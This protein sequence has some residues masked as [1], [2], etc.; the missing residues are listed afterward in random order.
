LLFHS[1]FRHVI[2][3][4]PT[5]NKGYVLVKITK[6]GQKGGSFR[7]KK[8]QKGGRLEKKKGRRRAVLIF[9]IKR[10][11]ASHFPLKS[12]FRGAEG[13]QKG[14]KGGNLKIHIV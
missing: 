9:F 7:E 12:S 3:T 10:D 2:S 11:T 8:G 4:S 5:L 1:A 13:G 14:Q 6:K